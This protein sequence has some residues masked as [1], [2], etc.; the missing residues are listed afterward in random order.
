MSGIEQEMVN[1][2]KQWMAYADEDM[3]LAEC[4]LKLTENC[5]FR[6]I[7][8]H[9]QQCAEKY[10]KAFLVYKKTDFPY[11]HNIGYLLELC[12]KHGEWVKT[13]EAAEELTPFAITTRYPGEDEEVSAADAANAIKIALQ[14]KMSVTDALKKENFPF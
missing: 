13:V 3:R 5:P 12:A 7:A 4:G 10:L 14:V 1:K 9:A 2:A 6:L 11:T 8:Y